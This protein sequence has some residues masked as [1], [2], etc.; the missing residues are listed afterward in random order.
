MNLLCLFSSV[1]M[2]NGGSLQPNMSRIDVT[3][4]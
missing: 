1:A 3:F 4:T 2:V